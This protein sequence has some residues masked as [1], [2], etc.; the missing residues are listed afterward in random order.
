MNSNLTLENIENYFSSNCE[1]LKW[2]K[3]KRLVK[4]FYTFNS[5]TIKVIY[6]SEIEEKESKPSTFNKCNDNN[7]FESF[8]HEHESFNFTKVSSEDVVCVYNKEDYIFINLYPSIDNSILITPLR[9]KKIPQFIGDEDIIERVLSI[10][11]S[12]DKENDKKKDFVIGYN[13]RG[14]SASINHLHFQMFIF[15]K[16]KDYDI[17]T[18]L[19]FNKNQKSVMLSHISD[20]KNELYNNILLYKFYLT[21]EKGK[22]L[23]YFRVEILDSSN[24]SCLS[25]EIYS[26]ISYLNNKDICYNI[27]IKN[28][29]IVII[30]RKNCD[31]VKGDYYFGMLEFMGIYVCYS[32]K[33]FEQ[34]NE[35]IYLKAMF[36]YMLDDES[37]NSSKSNT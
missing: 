18:C 20:D 23:V 16:E 26:V 24:I 11:L 19:F 21:S 9:D 8:N 32:K 12:F 28:D 3:D 14:A 17:N 6:P 37:I 25:K 2:K 30:P 15:N 22:S 36:Y 4:Y 1:R 5:S 34:L 27:L 31:L 13:S 33:E 10:K 35:E 29:S 7:I